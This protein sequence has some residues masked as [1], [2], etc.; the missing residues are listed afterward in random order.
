MANIKTN[1]GEDKRILNSSYQ[2]NRGPGLPAGTLLIIKK[3]NYSAYEVDYT[4][5]YGAYGQ[6]VAN[7]EDILNLQSV[8]RSQ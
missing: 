4:T 8:S 3:A 5:P 7:Q 6:F 1:N 2:P